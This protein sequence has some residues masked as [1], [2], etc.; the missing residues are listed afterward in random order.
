MDNLPRPVIVQI[1]QLLGDPSLAVTEYSGHQ[2]LPNPRK[3]FSSLFAT[4]VKKHESQEVQ[5][6]SV[7]THSENK[8]C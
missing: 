8:T 3:Y 5:E 2:L 6:M 4:K 7:P 1:L